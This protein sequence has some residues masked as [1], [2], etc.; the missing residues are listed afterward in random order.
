MLI[1]EIIGRI[2]ANC[3][4][5][6]IEVVAVAAHWMKVWKLYLPMIGS[7]PC[8]CDF[9]HSSSSSSAA[10]SVNALSSL[11]C[12]TVTCAQDSPRWLEAALGLTFS[13]EGRR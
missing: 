12:V 9:G 2:K 3:D 5:H 7:G 8:E 10:R 4:G 6:R 1:S 11:T 13:P